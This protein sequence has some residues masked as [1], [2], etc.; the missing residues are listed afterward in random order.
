MISSRFT[1]HC[2]CAEADAGCSASKNNL[3]LS[4][5]VSIAAA[6]LILLSFPHLIVIPAAGALLLHIYQEKA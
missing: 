2:A 5:S 4:V 6:M 1:S 3:I